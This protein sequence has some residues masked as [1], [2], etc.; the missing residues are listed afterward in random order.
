MRARAVLNQ[1]NNSSLKM[2][3]MT[4][5]V[6]YI[7]SHSVYIY[8]HSYGSSDSLIIPYTQALDLPRH[9]PDLP[10]IPLVF[11]LQLVVLLL[12]I[13]DKGRGSAVHGVTE[14]DMWV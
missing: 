6:I 9:N 14:T 2:I 8:I 7:Y 12:Q 3:V 11:L 4:S 5:S 13:L 10:R 1:Y